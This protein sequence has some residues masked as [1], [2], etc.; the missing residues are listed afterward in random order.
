MKA[1]NF[2]IQNTKSQTITIKSSQLEKLSKTWI[3]TSVKKDNVVQTGYTNFKLTM[4][5]TVGATSYGYATTGRPALSP[6]LSSGNWIF[7]TD[8]LIGIIRDKGTS[9]ELKITYTVTSTT[10]Q[11]SF[12]FIGAGYAGRV[13]DVKGLW[14]M[15][16]GL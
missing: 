6:W 11:I 9:D 3:A 14:V 2:S 7:E 5:G 16:F 10:L 13:E 12:N 15:T 1:T 8:P 4:A